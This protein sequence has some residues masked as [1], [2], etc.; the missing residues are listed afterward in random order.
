MKILITGS[1]G[2]IGSEAAEYF[3]KKDIRLLGRIIT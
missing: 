1:S 2:L 3:G